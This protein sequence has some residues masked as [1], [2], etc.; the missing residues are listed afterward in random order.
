M[1][2]TPGS[3]C[4]FQCVHVGNGTGRGGGGEGG[5]GQ[6]EYWSVYLWG[7]KQFRPLEKVALVKATKSWRVFICVC[8]RASVS[9]GGRGRGGGDLERGGGGSMNASAYVY[10]K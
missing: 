7:M 8:V 3:A 5:N 10:G 6:Q 9:L 2:P 1:S 4:V